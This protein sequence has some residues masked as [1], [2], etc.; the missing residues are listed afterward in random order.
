MKTQYDSIF[1][2][3]NGRTE[4]FHCILADDCKGLKDQIKSKH[5]IEERDQRISF[6]GVEITNGPLESYGIEKNS[7]L[8]FNIRI[9][10]GAPSLYTD[11][12]LQDIEDQWQNFTYVENHINRLRI[13][14][15]LDL[16]LLT[17]EGF[18]K[19][20]NLEKRCD[21]FVKAQANLIDAFHSRYVR[22][23][24]EKER[25]QLELL[26]EES[27]RKSKKMC[28]KLIVLRT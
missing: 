13:T 23:Q 8:D 15:G 18:F 20:L 1:L 6:Q 11:F 9:V 27:I 17:S 7:T 14:D 4:K 25:H 2:C 24:R 10:G 12:S 26:E 22:E 28:Q 21:L 16:L 5:R 3:I 19:S